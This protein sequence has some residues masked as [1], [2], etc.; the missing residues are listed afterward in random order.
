MSSGPIRNT[1]QRRGRTNVYLPIP[2]ISFLLWWRAFGESFM[3]V[4]MATVDTDLEIKNGFPTSRLL[5]ES[6]WIAE[7]K[8]L[9]RNSR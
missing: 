4:T 7:T 1:H 9:C 6:G 2:Q 8:K 5:P 3:T